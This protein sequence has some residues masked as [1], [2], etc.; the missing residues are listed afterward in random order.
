MYEGLPKPLAVVLLFSFSFYTEQWLLFLSWSHNL[1]IDMD[2]NNIAINTNLDAKSEHKYSSFV[3]HGLLYMLQNP[4]SKNFCPGFVQEFIISLNDNRHTKYCKIIFKMFMM[5]GN[6]GMYYV[7]HSTKT[8]ENSNICCHT[9]SLCCSHHTSS[10]T[11]CLRLT[12]PLFAAKHRRVRR[13]S[14][15]G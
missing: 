8:A 3:V 12:Q 9:S 5:L 6:A 10:C 11:F 2:D 4:Q 15:E 1:S 7:V 14:W 13:A